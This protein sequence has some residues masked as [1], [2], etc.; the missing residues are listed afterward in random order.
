MSRPDPRTSLAMALL[1]VLPLSFGAA[2]AQEPT[3]PP[4]T[5]AIARVSPHV[6]E[7]A[8][9]LPE[10]PAPAARRETLRFEPWEML[11]E[12]F[13][14]DIVLLMRHGPTDWSKRDPKDVAAADCERQRVLSPAGAA[15]MR[16]LGLLLA[17]NGI[18]PSKIVV[19]EW[20]RG[21]QTLDNL[22]VGFETVEPGYGD[23]VEIETDPSLNLLLSLQGAPNV[24]ALRRRISSWTGEGKAGPLLIISHFTNIAEITEFN[25][26]EGEILI[27]DPKRANRVLGYLR[28]RSAAPDVGHFEQGAAGIPR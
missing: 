4:A 17:G 9:A 11:D 20:C 6:G 16:D 22:L 3:R 10:S 18:K 2:L 8:V 24:T 13:R 5:S 25:V 28:L 12:L 7:M 14:P 21:Q 26:Y 15:N 19:S 27:V 23:L 1:A